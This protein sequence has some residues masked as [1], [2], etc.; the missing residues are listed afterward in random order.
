MTCS[1]TALNEANHPKWSR[2]RDS[3]GRP[4]RRPIAGDVPERHGLVRHRMTDRFR[5]ALFQ[6]QPVDACRIRPVHAGPAVQAVAEIGRHSRRARQAHEDGDES[7]IADPV[8]RRRK[9]H[10][11]GPHAALGQRPRGGLRS[12]RTGRVRQVRFGCAARQPRNAANHRRDRRLCR[13][14][15]RHVLLLLARP[16]AGLSDVRRRRAAEAGK[17]ARLARPSLSES[18]VRCRCALLPSYRQSSGA[19]R[20]AKR[21]SIQS[22]AAGAASRAMN[23]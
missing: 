5:R 15:G 19:G 3:T 11:C 1:T 17:A 23:R 9:P 13:R 21:L 4:S 18:A 20:P 8:N 6:R 12:A 22:M 7:A 2:G 14:H 16:E 10:G